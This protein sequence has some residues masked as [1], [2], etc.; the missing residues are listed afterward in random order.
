MGKR[1][2]QHFVPQFYFRQFS[3]GANCIQAFFPNQSRI[4]RN[5]PIK[6]QCASGRFYGDDEA[7]TVLSKLE[8]QYSAA[9]HS[10]ILAAWS[11]DPVSKITPSALNSIF[12]SIMV[13]RSRTRSEVNNS[14]A[15][16]AALTLEALKHHLRMSSE[17]EDHHALSLLNTHP[18]ELEMNGP[19]TAL[20]NI[21]VALLTAD[22]LSDLDFCI[23]RNQTELPFIFCDSPVIF[24]NTYYHNV[25]HRGVLGAAAPGLQIFLPLNST[26]VLMLYDPAKYECSYH[27]NACVDVIS[28]YDISQINALQIHGFDQAIYFED[29]AQY[30]YVMELWEAHRPSRRIEKKHLHEHD[31]WLLDGKSVKGL[32]HQFEPLHNI[33]LNLSFLTCSPIDEKDYQPGKRDPELAK[34]VDERL[35][36][37]LD[38]AGAKHA[39][40]EK[41]TG[42]LMAE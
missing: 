25:K 31:D 35:I 40:R 18:H 5:A 15:R 2:N 16:A 21:A 32:L 27:N 7:E 3:G 23:I 28:K 6:G 39:K 37:E 33:R 14:M 10:M 13:Q 24:H 1:I 9:L 34:I 22:I 4:V 30:S 41:G 26:L 17:P 12:E 19:A 11:D 29:H 38:A 20:Q 42:P 8:G 36:R